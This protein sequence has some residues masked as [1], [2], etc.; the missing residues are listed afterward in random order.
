MYIIPVDKQKKI[1]D[2]F[3]NSKIH[4][5]EICKLA[6]FDDSL[7]LGEV[8]EFINN[9][10]DEKGESLKRIKGATS[11]QYKEYINDLRSQRRINDRK[12]ANKKSEDNINKK[13]REKGDFVK[14][15]VEKIIELAT[16]GLSIE[17]IRDYYFKYGIDI[18]QEDACSR[19]DI[20]PKFKK[21]DDKLDI[22]IHE[23]RSEGGSYRTIS[24]ELEKDGIMI[25]YETI[26][27]MCNDNF[28]AENENIHIK[29][30]TDLKSM[31]YEIAKKK[32]A[33][34]K[35]LVRFAKEV[36]KMYKID[37]DIEDNIER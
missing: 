7:V 24:E 27:K 19:G 1:I 4:V 22:F 17:E 8:Y 20:L 14:V 3:C 15:S 21:I 31:I 25:S 10:R 5:D 32:K 26:R 16:D 6:D 18:Y 35:Q 36:S 11:E 33:N 30:K 37:L 9:Y 13:E 12:K 28:K 2:L 23:L 29:N 34:K